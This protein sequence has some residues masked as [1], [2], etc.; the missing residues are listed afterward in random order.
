[1][2]GQSSLYFEIGRKFR[3]DVGTFDSAKE[4]VVVWQALC[5][6]VGGEFERGEAG[7]V[8]DEVLILVRGGNCCDSAVGMEWWVRQKVYGRRK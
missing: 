8:V 7:R 5:A 4:C 2:C 3:T 6:S 1:M